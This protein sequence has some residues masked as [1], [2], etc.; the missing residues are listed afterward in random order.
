[1]DWHDY[2]LLQEPQIDCFSEAGYKFDKVKG[3]LEFHNVTF[4]YPSR[5][6][7]K[8]IFQ[9]TPIQ[10]HLLLLHL[11]WMTFH[12]SSH[13]FLTDLG[14][15]QFAGEVRWNNSICGSQRCR[16][17]HDYPA[18]PTLLWSK[19]RHG[20]EFFYILSVLFI[21]TIPNSWKCVVVFLYSGYI[22]WS[23]YPRFEYPMASFSDWNRGAGAGFVC[24]HHWWKHSV[25]TAWGLD[26]WHHQ[27]SQRG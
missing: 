13:F 3:D 16:E 17:E 22:R 15:A 19:R 27:G 4:H 12:I 1:M 9:F 8:V 14:S 2:F 11:V 7:V 18:H 6:E 24:H 20:K 23:W 25:R 21:Y 5:P 26:W 10:L